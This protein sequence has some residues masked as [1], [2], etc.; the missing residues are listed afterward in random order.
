MRA[1]PAK[2]TVLQEESTGAGD[3]GL[4]RDTASVSWNQKTNRKTA[5]GQKSIRSLKRAVPK[6]A[7][8]S[9]YGTPYSL[10]GSEGLGGNVNPLGVKLRNRAAQMPTRTYAT[11][12]E[13][14]SPGLS[15]PS[16]E[17]RIH[18]ILAARRAAYQTSFRDQQ[19][20]ILTLKL[21]QRSASLS[22]SP[23]LKA[24]SP[25]VLRSRGRT[26]RS[27]RTASPRVGGVGGGVGGAGVSRGSPTRSP[28]PRRLEMANVEMRTWGA[29]GEAEQRK[30]EEEARRIAA[31]RRV[32]ALRKTQ[33]GR[34]S[35][36]A[37]RRE[38]ARRN[39]AALKI[40]T[41]ARAKLA[42]MK[43]TQQ[44]QRHSALARAA[45][46]R[47][48]EELEHEHQLQQQMQRQRQRQ[49]AEDAKTQLQRRHETLQST[50][51]AATAEKAAAHHDGQSQLEETAEDAGTTEVEQKRKAP[52]AAAAAT[53]AKANGKKMKTDV[54]RATAAT[55][56]EATTR[57]R[58]QRRKI[59]QERAA[60]S[61]ARAM[62]RLK[63]DGESAAKADAAMQAVRD[64]ARS[65]GRAA[66][67]LEE[68]FEALDVNLD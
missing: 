68:K 38:A 30:A 3:A 37:R 10:V 58:L 6:S 59:L 49:Q 41:A 2:A 35:A 32:Q 28:V 45:V 67:A 31:L 60:A 57:G 55:K 16:T 33:E 5:R 9:P 65:G 15:G 20:L 13:G 51:E 66:S 24:P 18:R 21:A 64:M 12:G 56:I 29:G 11:H 42:R 25:S 61:P 53:G 50:Q 19:Q 40:E 1:S 23:T 47:K 39:A 22:P 4:A 14:V 54:E 43:R 8:L 44:A 26:R 62:D 36:D 7:R 17:D 48:R 46:E 63:Q 52:A 34:Q 27:D